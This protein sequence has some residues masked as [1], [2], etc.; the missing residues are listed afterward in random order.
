MTDRNVLIT[1]NRSN[2]KLRSVRNS[3]PKR[4][5]LIYLEQY[6]KQL[7]VSSF[8]RCLESLIVF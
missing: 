4:I 7:N 2:H 5:R 3:L 6:W 8:V 1:K